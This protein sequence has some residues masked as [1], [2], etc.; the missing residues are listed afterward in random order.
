MNRIEPFRILAVA[1]S[2]RGFGYAV[3]EM[4][5]SLVDYG[6]KVVKKD[7]NVHSLAQIEKMI[8]RNQPDVL[9]LQ[10]VN[11]KGAR[12]APRIKEL[13][14]RVVELA[15]RRRLKTTKISRTEA[16]DLLIGN[17][18]A[19]KH[20][21]AEMLAQRFP[22]ELAPRL[23]PKRKPWNSEDAR[24]DIFDAVALAVWQ[25]LRLIQK[26]SNPVRTL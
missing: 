10:D 5:N 24:M 23:P 11:A 19:S 3:M 8:N 15:K 16:R 2:T 17:R 6:N 14:R 20:E 26:T 22:D 25:K 1:L 4:E 21:V 18:K 9:V 7:R 12:R 13:H